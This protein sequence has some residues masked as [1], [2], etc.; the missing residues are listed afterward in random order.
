V[1]GL[2]EAGKELV[3]VGESPVSMGRNNPL[4]VLF[5]GRCRCVDASSLCRGWG[6][7]VTVNPP[8]ERRRAGEG[9]T[10]A[11]RLARATRARR[12]RGVGLHGGP[13]ASSSLPAR[14]TEIISASMEGAIPHSWL[15][16][17]PPTSSLSGTTLSMV[18]IARCAPSAAPFLCWLSG[19]IREKQC[20]SRLASPVA[21]G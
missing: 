14:I 3:V 15:M 10:E 18:S 21:G 11:L 6:S 12:R 13:A 17:R 5:R 4:A 16:S 20:S 7:P 1:P 2:A 8:H 9:Q 19:T